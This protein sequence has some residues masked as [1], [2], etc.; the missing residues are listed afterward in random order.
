MIILTKLTHNF[1]LLSH[2]DRLCRKCE[3]FI[4]YNRQ[5]T[6]QIPTRNML[7]IQQ[8]KESL[9]VLSSCTYPEFKFVPATIN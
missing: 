1:I 4:H 2:V 3:I 6:E 7:P 5:K 8:Q 9:V